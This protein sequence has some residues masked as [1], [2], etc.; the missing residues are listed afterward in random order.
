MRVW[1]VECRDSF[2]YNLVAAFARAGADVRVTD[3][4]A[5]PEDL[6]EAE[7]TVL[8]P[9]P[10]HPNDRA[11]LLAL[12]RVCS[13]TRPVLG[14]CLGHQVL[15]VAHGGAVGRCTPEHGRPFAITHDATGPFRAM[16]QPLHVGRYHS[17]A[18]HTV[19]PGWRATAHASDGV[20]MAMASA[21]GRSVGV[22]FHPESVLSGATGQRLLRA[23]LAH[24]KRCAETRARTL[25]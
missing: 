4:E 8:G 24:A 12:A 5:I 23:V 25:P 20:I 3:V 15:A 13:A 6:P 19:P 7:L 14:V 22:Q 16:P 11:S 10:G 17:L 21:D 2:S 18:V 1:L 9:G